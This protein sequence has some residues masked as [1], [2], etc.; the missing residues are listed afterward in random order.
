M[1]IE[2]C[3]VLAPK[4]SMEALC[5]G[6]SVEVLGDSEWRDGAKGCEEAGIYP[7]GADG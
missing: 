1:L 5:S 6:W 2:F 3:A 7:G 4:E